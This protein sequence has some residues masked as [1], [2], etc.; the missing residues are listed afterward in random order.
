MDHS[1]LEDSH[2]ELSDDDSDDPYTGQ[3]IP[4]T[5]TKRTASVNHSDETPRPNKQQS[6]RTPRAHSTQRAYQDTSATD[7]SGIRGYTLSHL[8]RVPE[9]RLLAR[10]VV[11]AE[12][13]RR[14]REERAQAKACQSQGGGS[15]SNKMMSKISALPSSGSRGPS[16]G[17]EG[18]PMGPKMKRL[19]RY[20]IQQLFQDGGIVL[21]DGPVRALP[22]SHDTVPSLL[23]FVSASSS[24][25]PRLWKGSS[26]RGEADHTVL[27]SISGI[28]EMDDP[29]YLSDPPPGEEAYIPLTT[30]YLS[31]VIEQTISEIMSS[32]PTNS[33]SVTS[34]L[35]NLSVT[36][37]S[38]RAG[39]T[40]SEIL[41][42]LQRRDERWERV[43][44]WAV[45]E[46]LDWGREQ[47]RVW[48]VGDGRWELCG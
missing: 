44:E 27:S 41:R 5:P 7:S 28:S 37:R 32:P 30:P 42:H 9:L 33:S 12:A 45:K 18:E 38:S 34:K 8:R 23:S 11:H 26:S 29:G 46:A 10:R 35:W 48:C 4:G 6:M 15:T 36:T 3:S 40:C 19:F 17:K 2:S 21:W 1:P 13:K 16:R 20:A 43:G 47:G 22:S 24:D 39:P 25:Q 31:T 14:T